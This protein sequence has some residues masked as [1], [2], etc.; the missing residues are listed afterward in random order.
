MSRTHVISVTD[1]VSNNRI[2][3]FYNLNYEVQKTLLFYNYQIFL[4]KFHFM[5]AKEIII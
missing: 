5:N 1:I 3:I 4:Y 2:I